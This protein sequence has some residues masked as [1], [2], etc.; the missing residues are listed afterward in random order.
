MV[1]RKQQFLWI[2][3]VL[4]FVLG[5]DQILK[6]WIVRTIEPHAPYRGDV[7][8]HFTHQRNTGLMG[9]SFSDIPLVAYIAP[10]IAFFVLIYMYRQLSPESRVQSIAYGMILGGALGNFIDRIRLGAVNDFFQF[11]FLFIPFDF[12]WK[13]YPAFNIAD[14]GIICGVILLFFTLNTAGTPEETT[15]KENVS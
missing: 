4:G 7:F 12:P 6:V 3:G 2:G 8:F 9:G 5:L 15:P 11:H 10:V 13:Y 14:S 1:T